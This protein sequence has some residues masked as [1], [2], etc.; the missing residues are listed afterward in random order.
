MT[1]SSVLEQLEAVKLNLQ[2]ARNMAAGLGTPAPAREMLV[3]RIESAI[4]LVEHQQE[5]AR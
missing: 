1:R 4:A 3:R 5:T 2:A